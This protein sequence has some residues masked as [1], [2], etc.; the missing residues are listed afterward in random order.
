[1]GRDRMSEVAGRGTCNGVESKFPRLGKGYRTTLSLREGRMCNGIIFYI[2]P[3]HPQIGSELVCPDKGCKSGMK[4]LVGSPSI[5][6]S[7]L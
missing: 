1:M 7:S 5:G 2:K 3:F 6:S 4:P